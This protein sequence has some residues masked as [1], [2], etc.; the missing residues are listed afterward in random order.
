MTVSH[1]VV[2]F[3]GERH[4]ADPS[5]AFVIGREGD[6]VIDTN[7]F[8]HRRLLELRADD[9]LWW[10]SNVGSALPVTVADGDG[11]MQAWLAPRGRLPV[12]F[13]VVSVWFTAGPTTYQ[14]EISVDGA[15][16]DSVGMV[17]DDGAEGPT[18]SALV[19]LT[20]E[21]TRVVAALC[22]PLIRKPSA[23]PSQIPTNAQAAERLGWSVTKYNRKL[24][25]V[26]QRLAARGVRGLYGGS[27]QLAVNRRARLVEYAM[28]TR[29]VVL[30]DVEALDGIL[31]P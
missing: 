20:P 14:L 16:Y 11:V 15:P 13:P 21:Q 4:L 31:S 19:A 3:C 24:D 7:R 5:H 12:V 28:S 30:G 23:S 27:E 1:A 29:L 18:T 26:C 22:E 9:E 2:D 6:L 25:T 10:L 8:L 17:D